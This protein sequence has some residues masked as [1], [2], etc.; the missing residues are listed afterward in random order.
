MRVLVAGGAGFLG[1][2]LV[3]LLVAKGDEV[4]ILDNYFTG[5]KS[6]LL[7]HLTN[8]RVEII[9]H[10]VTM[11]FYAEVDQIFNLAS[12]ASPVHY[13][14]FPVQ[15]IKTNI[16]GSIN[17]LGLARR[18]GARILQASTSEIYGDP[19]ESPQNEGYWGNVNPIG[20]RACYD[21]GKRASET[22]FFDYHRQYGIEIKV[23]RI[24]N[25]YG[26]RMANQDGRV[27]SNFI[28]QAL[29]NSPITIYGDGLQTRSFCYV[30]DLVKGICR[31]MN[32]ESKFIGPV[33]LGNPNECTM[34]EAAN[35]I[36]NLTN[37]NSAIKFEPLPQ[38][39]PRRRKPDISLAKSELKWE[40][41]TNFEQGLLETIDYFQQ[42]IN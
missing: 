21:E 20:I 39:D 1:S 24:F 22:L 28:V 4:L 41:D 23:V 37:S 14:K 33:N 29:T 27:I 8:P 42:I 9:R 38:D 16:L 34:L 17:L 19:I 26:P 36:L 5:S 7:H 30:S 35:L 15:T 32:S 11:P 3:D 25:T 13:Q 6:N 10:D 40:P 2:H 31:M 12:P 18:T